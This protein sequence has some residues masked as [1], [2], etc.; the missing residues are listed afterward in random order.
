MKLRLRAVVS[1]C[2]CLVGS[3]RLDPEFARDAPVVVTV[4]ESHGC[5]LALAHGQSIECA[6]KIVPRLPGIERIDAFICD[7]VPL[8]LGMRI[9]EVL[10]DLPADHLMY[11]DAKRNRVSLTSFE[12]PPQP[13]EDSLDDI[14][15]RRPVDTRTTTTGDGFLVTNKQIAVTTRR[16]QPTVFFVAENVLEVWSGGGRVRPPPCDLPH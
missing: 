11:D 6:Q 7:V 4:E 1:R 9:S 15:C 3:V 16:N 12:F 13:F 8:G 5:G 2:D 10:R 14:V